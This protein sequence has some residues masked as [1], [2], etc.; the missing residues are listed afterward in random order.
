MTTFSGN[1]WK[2]K[3]S[4]AGWPDRPWPQ[5]PWWPPRSRRWSCRAR[6]SRTWATASSSWWRP[7]WGCPPVWAGGQR[8]TKPGVQGSG[9]GLRKACAFTVIGGNSHKTIEIG[10][11]HY[12][13]WPDRQLNVDVKISPLA[14][15]I[16]L[17]PR[18]TSLLL[19]VGN[20]ISSQSLTEFWS[21]R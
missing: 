21:E 5:P 3:S 10:M 20:I 4:S 12:Q 14:K 7:W 17:F 9:S 15:T 16:D 1:L 6:P 18:K 11:A 2:L 19:C 13:A 8:Q